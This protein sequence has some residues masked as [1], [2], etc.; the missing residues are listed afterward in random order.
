GT[1][2]FST[3]LAQTTCP[4][5]FGFGQFFVFLYPCMMGMNEHMRSMMMMKKHIQCRLTSIVTSLASSALDRSA[6]ACTASL[7]H[8][9]PFDMSMVHQW[10][11]R[12]EVV[13]CV[14]GDN[15][16]VWPRLLPLVLLYELEPRPQWPLFSGPTWIS[17]VTVIT[18]AIT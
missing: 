12:E 3:T 2:V 18:S 17:P 8:G 11:T 9:C 1:W 4:Y 5:T 16:P 7:C 15:A 10:C 14:M 6:D 13:M